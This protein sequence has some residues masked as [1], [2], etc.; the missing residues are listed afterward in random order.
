[1]KDTAQIQG[2]F[3]LALHRHISEV[4]HE[5][6]DALVRNT[7]FHTCAWMELMERS[8][9]RDITPYYLTVKRDN[10]LVGAGVCY[11]TTR[12]LW[13]IRV[14]FVACTYPLSE[15]MSLFIKEG[16]DTPAVF[17]L[18]YDGL[19]QV[20]RE[21]RARMLSITY[22][23]DEVHSDFLKKRG[24]SMMIQMPATYLDI[25]WK[26]FKEYLGSLSR[27][28]KKNIRHTLNQ[29]ER[30][31]L[32][33][34]HSHNFEDAER[35]HHLYMTSLERHGYENL[36]PFTAE[37]YT[38]LE[39][40]VRDHAY[41]LRC[42]RGEDLLGYWVYFFDGNQAYMTISA[43]D[44]RYAREY[45]AYFNI[46]YEAVREMIEKGSKRISFGA[47]T[48]TVKLRIG[49]DLKRR[50]AS[51]KAMNPLLNVALKLLVLLRNVW[52]ERRYPG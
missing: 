21:N 17:S 4:P 6:W 46:C 38:N 41:I 45:D 15:K 12:S 35:L 50:V 2:N 51:I 40:Y 34:E 23:S 49:C 37:F 31:G 36:V 39:K 32:T 11:V 20:A 16:E 7:M 24:F 28:A 14:S 30:K 1:M 5:E 13:K 18:L 48:Y 26:T 9:R 3:T 29:G 52:I 8:A 25:R 33:L 44:Q 42:C 27:K 10:H 47:T 43:I 22:V 19:E